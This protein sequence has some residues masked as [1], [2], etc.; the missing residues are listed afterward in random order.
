M[1]D[2]TT[3]MP[4]DAERA[5]GSVTPIPTLPIFFKLVGRRVL[6]AGGSLPA[7]WKAE[8]LAAAGAK[9]L[10]CDPAPCPD[11]LDL[12]RQG[13]GTIEWQAR[14]W[15]AADFAD[16]A[17]AIGVLEGDEAAAFR[18]A[19]HRA[20]VP[21]NL[22]DIP[23]LCDF[24]FAT[25]IARSPLL[26]AI[27]TDGAAPVFGQALRTRIEALLPASIQAWAQ[28]AKD[29]RPTLQ[30]RRLGFRARRRF[31]EIFADR[32]LD[33]SG[34]LPSEADRTACFAA[35][36]SEEAA[37]GGR[38]ILVGIGPGD[39]DLVT[40]RAVRVLQS[41][42]VI[43]Y[44]PGVSRDVLALGRREARHL[45]ETA[46]D[47]KTVK[48]LDALIHESKNVAWIGRGDPAACGRWSE[49][50]DRLGDVALAYAFVP[51]LRCDACPDGCAAR[52]SL[53]ARP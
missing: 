37:P 41:A 25:I 10:V 31:W 52:T 7:V 23:E 51:A 9:V 12:A 32:A 24:Q 8:L 34:D 1:P 27:S 22:V 46:S 50:R 17:L 49:R 47:E 26:I 20:G 45:P 38:L 53:N 5:P 30:D 3:Q 11:M 35:A 33:G 6:L 4:G 16:A 2:D 21:V 43:V 14:A 28:A 29:W 19:A 13:T 18:D 42:D 48:M 15:A 39:A 40:L 44:E 36:R